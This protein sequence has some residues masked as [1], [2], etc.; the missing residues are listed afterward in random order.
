MI[1]KSKRNIAQ[2]IDVI[3][4]IYVHKKPFNG[5]GLEILK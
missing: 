4:Q 5:A 2:L 3:F 1:Q